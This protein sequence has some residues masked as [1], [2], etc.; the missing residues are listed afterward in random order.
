MR[1][2]SSVV[3]LAMLG[4]VAH[5]QPAPAAPPQQGYPP[6]QQ[7]YPP[8][9]QQ[10]YPQQGYPQQYP[11]GY[12]PQQP[13]MQVQ[14]TVDDQWLLQRGYISDGEYIGGGLVAL[15]IGF[16]V[17]QA[18]QGRWGEKGWIFT[19]GE[20]VSIAAL[21]YGVVQALSCIDRNRTDGSGT[22]SGDEGVGVTLIGFAG[23]SVFRVWETIDAFAAP[24]EHNRK[25]RAL[26]ARLGMPEPMYSRLTP[27]VS[28][29][30]DRDGGTAGVTLRF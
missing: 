2:I 29:T 18:V 22:C 11:P 10:G 1:T 6:P 3:L 8:P 12:S 4:S 28:P 30:R 17:G 24:P 20:G 9:P 23:F 21:F 25:V 19:L 5:A 15:F 7:G 26:R 13:P 27:Y 16:G 14:L